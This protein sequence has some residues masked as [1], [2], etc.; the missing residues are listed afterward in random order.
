MSTITKFTNKTCTTIEDQIVAILNKSG[1]GVTFEGATRS[2][3]TTET[4]FKIVGTIVGNKS[5]KD[6]AFDDAC[7]A[8]DIDK[9]VKGRKGEMLIGY[10]PRARRHPFIYRTVRGAEYIL[11]ARAWKNKLPFKV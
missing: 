8:H 11:D 3:G 9:T 4:T 1:L 5:N 7:F 10:R 2:Y 6:Q